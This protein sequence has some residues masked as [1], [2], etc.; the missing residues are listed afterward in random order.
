MVVGSN[1]KE[2]LGKWL[3]NGAAGPQRRVVDVGWALTNATSSFIYDA[4]RAVT[5]NDIVPKHA[6]SASYCPAVLDHEARLFEIPCPFDLELG[7]HLDDKGQPML[8]NIAGDQSAIRSKHLGQV[9]SLAARKEWRHPDR[10]MIQIITPYVFLADE[11]VYMTQL[12]PFGYYRDP[13]LPGCLVGG[14]LPIHIWPRQMMWA[15]EWYEPSKPIKL[16]RGEPWF[17]V[18]FE[19]HDPSRPVRMVEAQMTPELDEYMKGLA[20]VTNYVQRTFSLFN[21]AKERRPERLLVKKERDR[22]ST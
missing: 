11:P 1:L 13:P 20:G 14:R 12:P 16:K 2:R 9:S 8:R 4:P 15:L 7:Y 18:R 10:P 3:G 5:R 19:T 21:T 17:Y 22:A 6:K